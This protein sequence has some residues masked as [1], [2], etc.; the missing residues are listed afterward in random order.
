MHGRKNFKFPH[1]ENFHFLSQ[2]S[3]I[4]QMNKMGKIALHIFVLF[5][6]AAYFSNNL[7]YGVSVKK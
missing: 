3:T 7:L 5:F 2:V 4:S 1:N 6:I